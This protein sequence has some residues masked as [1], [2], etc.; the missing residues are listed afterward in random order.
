MGECLLCNV[1]CLIQS[2]VERRIKTEA[3]GDGKECGRILRHGKH[4]GL[5]G[6]D[7]LV[8]VFCPPF[9]GLIGMV[10]PPTNVSVIGDAVIYCICIEYG[11]AR[12]SVTSSEV[13]RSEGTM[14]VLY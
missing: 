4:V 11:F 2:T 5:T 14:D 7:F 1:W 12:Y 3:L 13:G 9:S 10:V 6:G 8:R